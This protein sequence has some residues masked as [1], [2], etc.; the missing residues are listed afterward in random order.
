MI[1]GR[2]N[3]LQ[4][5]NTIYEKEGSQILVVYGQK[6]VGKT[7]LL[8][9][10]VKGKECFYYSASDNSE[11]GQLYLLSRAC[12]NYQLDVPEYPESY[13]VI[14]E[15]VISLCN[16]KKI[17][18]LEGFEHLVKASK[19][20]M[21]ALRKRIQE[22]VGECL[23][24][25]CSGSTT[26]VENDLV[27]K[28]G[29]HALAISGFLK[30]KELKFSDLKQYFKAYNTQECV[31]LYCIL[32]GIPGLWQ[33][34]DQSL[35]I[36]ENICQNILQKDCVL[37]KEGDRIVRDSLRE[38]AVYYSILSALAE[39]KN[40]L[41]DLYLHTEYSRA[42]ISVYLKNLMELDIVT[43]IF[44]IDTPGRD[45]QKKGLYKISNHFVRFWFHFIYPNVSLL[46]MMKPADY[47]DQL[48]KPVLTE[49]CQEGYSE[50]C[51]QTM[52]EWSGADTIPDTFED[53]GCF[54][55]K[56]GRIDFI[57][58]NEEEEYVVA[59]SD[60]SD[61][62]L[63]RAKLTH[64]I[65]V[66]QSAKIEPSRIYLFHKTGFDEEIALWAKTK[67]DLILVTLE[68]LD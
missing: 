28:I 47:Y 33:Y 3:E 52:E 39:G 26:F 17:I 9:D 44:S 53:T 38:P 8:M 4:Y 35:S 61:M 22:N 64:Y 13:S 49:F 12:K 66:I 14:W 7:T 41:N 46:Q 6:N 2:E 62:L 36:R 11:R 51:R 37:R 40:K 63:S 10:F 31:I 56:T 23:V 19:D 34:M 32:G 43:K 57:G 20:F 50:I 24:I 48:I 5:L 58:Q 25:L 68:D 42:K 67:E 65:E 16:T 60:F 55:G 30:I 18:I 29:K 21:P 54:E 15:K 1:L 27:S 45:N 59:F